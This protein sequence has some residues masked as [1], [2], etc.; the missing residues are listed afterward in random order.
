MIKRNFILLFALFIA[1]SASAT[2]I[3]SNRVIVSIKPLHSLV[4]GV[5]GDTGKAELLVDGVVSPHHMQLK[6]SQ[7]KS[8]Q[9]AH[10][11]FYIDDSFETF[12]AHVFDILSDDVLKVPMVDNAELMLLPYRK[13][14]D[15]EVHDHHAHGHEGHDHHADEH[16]GHDHHADKHEVHDHH[17]DK[18]EGHD[19][20]ADGHEGH[21]YHADKHE[22]H[23]HHADK[24]QGH[25]HHADEHEGHD[26]H[27]DEHEGHDHHTDEH[28]GHDHH[29]DEHEGHNSHD[30]DMHVWLDL[31]NAQQMVALIAD[32]LSDVYP[33][34]RDIY[35]AN[36]QGL[37]QKIDRLNVELK[38]E[39]S[40]IQDKP[41]I[42]FHDAYQYFEHAYGL[43]GVGSIVF[44]GGESL[45]PVRIK[46]VREKLQRTGAACIFSEPQ[47]P[48]RPI[49][50]IAEGFDIKVSV[51]DPLGA[52]LPN[53]ENLYFKLLGN[54]AQ[55]LTQCLM[56]EN[57][58]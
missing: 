28:E 43:N 32:T 14:K 54:L 53:D 23:D 8:M 37:M 47:F 41:F 46:S 1:F 15:W 10:I 48:A 45:S 9:A 18:H 38:A 2:E 7:I 27:A 5:L 50:T 33:E 16:E 34:H 11:I 22:G 31:E 29:A 24:H 13:G 21:D 17:A 30:M 40:P 58:D 55:N 51:L 49:Q 42:V 35:Q 36:A 56:A 39:L 57:K 20:H 25:D 52:K 12:L 3:E 19:H 6:P 4:A 44:E 26:H